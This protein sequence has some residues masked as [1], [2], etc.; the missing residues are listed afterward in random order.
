MFPHFG[1]VP[2]F[3]RPVSPQPQPVASHTEASPLD[4]FDSESGNRALKGC[5]LTRS[6]LLEWE[7]LSEG[8]SDKVDDLS[9]PYS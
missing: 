2:S 7:S 8:E 9:V 1:V 4:V 5:D 6:T 3:D